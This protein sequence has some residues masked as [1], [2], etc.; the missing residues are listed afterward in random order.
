MLL[1]ER[2]SKWILFFNLIPIFPL[3]GGKFIQLILCRFISY[4]RSCQITLYLSYFF[5][6]S[7]LIYIIFSNFN[8][9]LILIFVILFITLLKEIKK[10][11]YYYQRF[12]LERYLNDYFF[13]R[14]KK[15]KSI[16]SIKRD[17]NHIIYNIS[18]KEYLKQYFEV[19]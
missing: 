2:Y 15:I 17:T 7:Y 3:D 16:K 4:Y 13:K 19:V 10:A 12:L 8:F 5:V 14:K 18:E 6:I 11:D 9:V 1:F